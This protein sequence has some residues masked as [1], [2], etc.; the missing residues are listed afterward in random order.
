MANA[1]RF[2]LLLIP[3]AGYDRGLLGGIARYAHIHGPWTFYLSG[4]HT[5]VPLAQ[6][7]SLSGGLV[8][9][10]YV[11]G[12]VGTTTLPNLRRWARHRHYRPDPNAAACPADRCHGFAVGLDRSLGRATRALKHGP[13]VSEI[14]ADSH[15]A[16]R[17]AAEHFLERR[18]SEFR[19]LRIRRP[20]LV[21]S[22]TGGFLRAAPRSRLLLPHLRVVPEQAKRVL[23]LGD[24]AGGGL[25]E[26]A[27]ETGRHPGLQR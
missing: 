24:A 2:V 4:D 12:S 8:G 10:D 22:P 15:G 9:L 21:R 18:V 3:F 14:R 11:W 17:L 25:A 20:A 13:G 27:A 19:L 6:P 23:E 26:V 5:G 1:A 7:E 16:G